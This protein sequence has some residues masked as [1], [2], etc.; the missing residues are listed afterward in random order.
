MPAKRPSRKRW[1]QSALAAHKKGALH[2]Q[3]GVP[4]DETIPLEMLKWA[5]TQGGLLA[6]R[7][8]FALVMRKLQLK[9]KAK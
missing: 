5:S 8:R 6:M 4:E 2:R 9:R 1:I 3:L 7:A